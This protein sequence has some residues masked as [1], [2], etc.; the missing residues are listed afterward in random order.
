M[1]FMQNSYSQNNEDTFVLNYFGDYKGNVLDIGA[2]DGYLFSNSLLLIQNGWEAWCLEPSSVCADLM[3]MHVGNPKVHIYNYGIGNKDGV[4]NFWESGAH[5]PNGTDRGLVST[6][7]FEETKRWP[8]VE[9]IERE[10]QI[11]TFDSF[12]KY[13][14]EPKFDFISIDVEGMEF[15][16]LQQIDLETV[17]CRV[18]CIEW[19]TNYDLMRQYMEYCKGYEIGL[20]NAENIIFC[21]K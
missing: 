19:N 11:V 4:V 10:I 16:I 8:N 12:Y 13:N 7:N 14:D 1:K 15:E 21:K 5:V 18:L 17:G 6:A 3:I 9:F 20:V 2:N